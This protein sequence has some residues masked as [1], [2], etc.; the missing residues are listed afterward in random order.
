MYVYFQFFANHKSDKKNP[1]TIDGGL[2]LS[3]HNYHIILYDNIVHCKTMLLC[4]L[5]HF[6]NYMYTVWLQYIISYAYIDI[7]MYF[8]HMR[9]TLVIIILLFNKSN[10]PNLKTLGRCKS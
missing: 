8:N 2:I 4:K 5:D 6:I 7:I 1:V 3:Y 9:N 10:I